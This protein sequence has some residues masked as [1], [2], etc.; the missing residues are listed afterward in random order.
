MLHQEMFTG[1]QDWG[2]GPPRGVS[3]CLPQGHRSPSPAC[4]VWSDSLLPW[5]LVWGAPDLGVQGEFREGSHT[6]VGLGAT[7]DPRPQPCMAGCPS[8]SPI[9]SSG[10][11]GT[12]G[13]SRPSPPLRGPRSQGLSSELFVPL[14]FMP[15]SDGEHFLL[16]GAGRSTGS[17]P[18]Q[19]SRVGKG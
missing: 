12:P 13:Q 3:T 5:A 2:M 7:G 1:S 9:R 17:Q 4:G 18:G 11:P 6:G 19:E 14:Y 10:E 16:I 8:P 15:C